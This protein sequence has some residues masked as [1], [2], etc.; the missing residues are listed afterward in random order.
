V[1]TLGVLV[2]VDRSV[3]ILELILDLKLR[4]YLF[5]ELTP[6]YQ[7]STKVRLACM[8]GRLSLLL[9]MYTGD[10]I[11]GLVKASCYFFVIDIVR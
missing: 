11:F 6:S 1:V 3:G 8:Q 2:G 9:Y 5:M 10:I 7:I 4:K